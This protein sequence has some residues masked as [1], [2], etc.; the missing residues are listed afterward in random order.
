MAV[1]ELAS[2]ESAEP[3]VAPP[4]EQLAEPPAVPVVEFGLAFAELSV[5]L[6]GPSAGLA[7]PSAEPAVMLAE[8]P[9]VVELIAGTNHLT[10]EPPD[11]LMPMELWLPYWMPRTNHCCRFGLKRSPYQNCKWLT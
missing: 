5:E 10:V 9:P 1:A 2:A 11:Q 7:E 4:A 8:L 3:S 6:L